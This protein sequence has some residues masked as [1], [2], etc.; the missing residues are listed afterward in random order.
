MNI[1]GEYSLPNPNTPL[2][3]KRWHLSSVNVLFIAT[4]RIFARLRTVRHQGSGI[5]WQISPSARI[6]SYRK[7][8]S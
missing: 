6:A 3:L 5:Q 8:D 4:V 2:G 1:E 7:S